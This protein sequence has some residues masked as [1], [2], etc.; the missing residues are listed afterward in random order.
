MIN[1]KQC[2]QI[3][4]LILAVLITSYAMADRIPELL[5]PDSYKSPVISMDLSSDGRI[6]AAMIKENGIKLWEVPSGRLIRIIPN[7]DP[8]SIPD[9]VH[10]PRLSTTGRSKESK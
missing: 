7:I 4:T 3:Q 10:H 6:L 9:S 8:L 2:S 1:R 5:L